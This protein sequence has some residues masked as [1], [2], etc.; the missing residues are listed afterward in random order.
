P[1]A[2]RGL[3]VAGP[4]RAAGGGS[5][6]A[7]PR[8]TPADAAAFGALSPD[9]AHARM[10]D[11]TDDAAVART[12]GD[13]ESTV[14]PIDVV[15]A[16]AGYGVEGIFEETPIDEMRAQFATNVFGVAATLQSAL[17]YMRQ[18]R[19]GQLRARTVSGGPV[20]ARG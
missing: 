19:A 11:V 3:G 4:G 13:V 16:N 10:L 14:G 20:A 17:P 2:A 6:G 5:G 12:I 15:I 8:P 18:R 1:G 9:R 7:G